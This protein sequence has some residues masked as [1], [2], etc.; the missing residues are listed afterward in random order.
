MKVTRIFKDYPEKNLR[1]RK[2]LS[3][4]DA[5]KKVSVPEIARMIRKLGRK[6]IK[7]TQ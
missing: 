3:V 2:W 4:P 5:A 1:K 7:K 6:R